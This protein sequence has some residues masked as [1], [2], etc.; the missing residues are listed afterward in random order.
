MISVFEPEIGDTEAAYVLDSLKRGMISGT[1]RGDY[2]GRFE[3]LAAA[4]CETQFGVT[5]TSGTTA[6]ALAVASLGLTAGDEVLVPSLTNIATAF[7]V[8]YAG[9]KPVFL[10]SEDITWNIDPKRIREKVTPRTRAI[11]PVHVYGH[12][13]DMDP[14][15]SLAAEFGLYVIEDNAESHGGEYKGRRTGGI[16]HIGCLSFY[17]NKIVTTGEGGMLVTNDSAIAEK[18][19]CLKNLGYSDRDRYIHSDLGYNF[20][21]TNLQAAIGVAQMEKIDVLIERR[22]RLASMYTERLRGIAGLHLPVEQPWAKNVYWMYSLVLE[23]ELASRD[24][25]RDR[26]LAKGIE[27][28]NFFYP[29]HRQ[30]VFQNMGIVAKD[31]SLPV[32]ESL[33]DNGLY[34]PSSPSLP[35]ETIDF[36]CNAFRSALQ[37]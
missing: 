20:R 6:L 37:L 16:G 11:I 19:R 13:V 22:R 12:P 34:L 29:L 15:M 7:A 1:I 25:V 28:R 23:P 32:S 8:L 26:L 31:E 3:A 36:I 30:P 17:I 27:T 14:V 33:G 21:L 24:S 4:S 5:T 2:T 9:A 35:E 10:D 18:A